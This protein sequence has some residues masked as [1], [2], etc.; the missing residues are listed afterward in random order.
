MHLFK[1]FA[2]DGHFRVD[3][4]TINPHEK[5]LKRMTKRPKKL[6]INR[7][8]TNITLKQA[9]NEHKRASGISEE[10]IVD[11]FISPTRSANNLTPV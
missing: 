10:R 5:A 1:N 9:S 2:D 11:L 6:V 7:P 4:P 3:A 8:I